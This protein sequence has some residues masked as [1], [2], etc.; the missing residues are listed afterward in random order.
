MKGAMAALDLARAFEA[1]PNPYM[2][3]DRD[4]R[5]VAMNQA[6]LDAVGSRR[7]VLV[8]TRLLDAFPHDPAQPDNDSTRLLLASFERVLRTGKP[9][10]LPLI[11]YRMPSA[12]GQQQEDRYWSATHTPL[13]GADG[14]VEHILQHT[15]DVTELH[16][17]QLRTQAAVPGAQPAAQVEAGL[18]GRAEQAQ[19]RSDG[20]DSDLR[21]LQRILAQSPGFMCF[22][23]GPEH[24]F[25]LSNAAYD[26]LVGHRPLYGRTVRE[27]LPEVGEG[28]FELLDRVCQS[29]EPFVG[30]SVAVPIEQSP[31]EPPV[32]R[33]VDFVYQPIMDESGKCLGVFVL[34]HDITDQRRAQAELGAIFDSFPESL[35]VGDSTGIKRVNAMARDLLGFATIDELKG[36]QATRMKAVQARRLDGTVLEPSESP[37]GRA[38]RGLATRMEV[39]CN[40]QGSGEELVLLASGAPVELGKEIIGAV[41]TH[42]DITAQK[43]AEREAR[44]LARVLD[45]TR[46][47]VGISDVEGRPAFVNEAGLRLMGLAD[48]E[49]ARRLPVADYFVPA[50]RER[51]RTEVLEAALRD[52]YW[53]GELHFDHQGTHE[54]IPVMYS[55]F[56]L[57]DGD[58]QLIGLATITRDLRASKAAE[59]ERAQLLADERRSRAQAE[60]ANRLKDHFLA[61]ISHELRTPLTAMLG[62]IDMLQSGTL[63]PD[64][65]QRALD[66]VERNARMQAQLIEDLLDVSRIISG[67]LALDLQALDVAG[68][69]AAAVETVRPAAEAKDVRLDVQVDPSGDV[70]GDGGR[71]QQVVWNLLANAVKFTPR[72][73]TVRLG[74][75]R[76]GTEVL[77]TVAD[78]GIGIA[79]EFLPHVF[80]RFRQADPGNA[81]KSG[82]LGLGLSIVKHV[83]EAHG[84]EVFATSAGKGQGATFTVRL[85][86]TRA[87]V[88]PLVTA[89]PPARFVAPAALEG[90]HIL[91]VEDEEDTREYLRALLQKARARVTVVAS[92]R[93]A[94]AA[95]RSERPDVLLSDLGMPE[96]DGYQLIQRVRA[97]PG[98]QGGKTPAVALTAY[99]RS[100]D[101][102]R[103]MLAGFQNH[104]TKPIEPGELLAVVAALR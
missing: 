81:R 12:D 41:V 100:E 86:G 4:L 103:A 58:G 14:Q 22:M 87:A 94:M 75:E 65:R 39:V 29:G 54:A 85:P 63:S 35:F 24:V 46:D 70:L 89:A 6:Y 30:K 3:V 88:R 68:V 92:A 53:E 32:E 38:L 37:Y 9:D 27:A 55:V 93:E 64:K 40:R 62:W 47:F 97:L 82:G 78:D 59:A 60:E 16:R 50:E 71:L 51:V 79:P 43:R 34:G 67:K 28:F 23:R 76:Q 73:G 2:V 90:M 49:A 33:L 19:A 11:H 48:L 45:A 84:G 101:R 66:T 56:P 74:L 96:E 17:Q 80:E 18:L 77:I 98:D 1:S 52:G 15:V 104:V 25:E 36:D 95:L 26:R 83:V 13:L 102:T 69:I 57:R 20:L 91:V 61:T 44:R 8:G 10:V 7:E 42:I 21:R 99:A 5:F 31:G 72:G